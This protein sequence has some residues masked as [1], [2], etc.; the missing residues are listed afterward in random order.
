M[1]DQP[2][3]FQLMNDYIMANVDKMS[4]GQ[5]QQYLHAEKLNQNFISQETREA[6]AF[7][8]QSI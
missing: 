2:E 7:R 1:K 6:L 3:F 5:I 4:D 8:S